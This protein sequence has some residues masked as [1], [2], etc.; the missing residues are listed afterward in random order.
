MFATE[1]LA[2]GNVSLGNPR[3]ITNWPTETLQSMRLAARP[4][5]VG[6]GT[7]RSHGEFDSAK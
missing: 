6:R 4:R 3:G 2:L 1:P 7:T 5:N